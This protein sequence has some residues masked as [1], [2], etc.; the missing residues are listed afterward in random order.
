MQQRIYIDTSVF[1]GYFETEFQLWSKRL[2]NKVTEQKYKAVVS[3][4]TLL[5]LEPALEYVKKLAIEVTSKYGEF[6]TAGVAEKELAEMYLKERIV[7]HRFRSDALHIA[8]ASISKVD[9]LVSWNFKHIVNL[10]R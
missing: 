2:I 1:G 6:I 5:E 9:I 4:I 8:I 3:D 10:N 7:T